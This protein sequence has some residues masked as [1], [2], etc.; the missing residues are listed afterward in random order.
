MLRPPTLRGRARCRVLSPSLS[1]PPRLLSCGTAR[2]PRCQ[3]GQS[4]PRP[5]EA[6]EPMAGG[7][8]GGGEDA[9][10]PEAATPAVTVA[11]GRAGRVRI[12]EGASLRIDQLRAEDQGWY[13]CRVLFLDR[14]S[15]DAD[16]QNG[17]W[18][19]LTVNGT[20]RSRPPPR[21]LCP[22]PAEI[23]P[24]AWGWIR[25]TS[26]NLGV[27]VCIRFY[28]PPH[29]P[30][31]PP[32]LRGGAGPRQAESHLPSRR[33]PPARRHLEEKRPGCPERGHGAGEDP[34]PPGH[35]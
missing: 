29:L 15:T 5:G 4:A 34:N 8:R 28:S 21:W 2:P 18:I 27:R 9:A 25:W 1:Q 35:P 31:D 17:T 13:E 30:G 32:R 33:Q 7:D 12:E 20:V 6:A 23:S 3:V 24:P 26:V 11:S 22:V 16:F 10:G 14:H 19:H